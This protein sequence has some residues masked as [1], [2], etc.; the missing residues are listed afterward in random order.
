MFMA[1]TTSSISNSYARRKNDE[2]TKQ[3]RKEGK[4]EDESFQTLFIITRKKGVGKCVT[5]RI[6]K[7]R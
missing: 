1:E 6:A 5:G 2:T 3:S 7:T 4:N